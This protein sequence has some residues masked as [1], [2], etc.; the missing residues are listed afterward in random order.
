MR[1]DALPAIAAV[2]L[3]LTGACSDDDDDSI[4]DGSVPVNEALCLDADAAERPRVELIEPALGLVDELYG[5]PRE[6]LEVSADRRRVSV[7]VATDEDT[8]EQVFYCG[9]AGYAGPE[10]FDTAAASFDDPFP[11]AAVDIDDDALFDDIYADLDD[12]DIVDFAVTGAGGGEVLYDAAVES[13]AGGI[14]LV[15]LS[16]DGEILAVQTQ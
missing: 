4:T 12:P 6:Y 3:L 14:L 15:L 1:A 9:D 16:G 10:P 11:A 5:S 7:I 2:T 13:D 8:A